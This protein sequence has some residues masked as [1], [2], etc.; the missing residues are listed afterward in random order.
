MNPRVA[1][2][3]PKPG[4]GGVERVMHQLAL[5]LEEIGVEADQLHLSDFPAMSPMLPFSG[6]VLLLTRHLKAEGYTA[7]I[8][9][10]E[11]ANLAA[12]LAR[13]AI[14]IRL[15]T[16]VTRHVPTH[17][18]GRDA[19][20]YVPHLYR[21]VYRHADG[22]IGVSRGIAEELTD[23]VGPKRADRVAALPNAVIG[24]QFMSRANESITHDWLGQSD[25]RCVVSVGRLAPQKGLELWIDALKQ[26]DAGQRPRWIAIGDGPQRAELTRRVQQSGLSDDVEFLGA[27]EN[28]LPWLKAADAMVLPSRYE[29]LPTVLIEALTLGTPCIASDC[30]TGPAEIAK[31]GGRLELIDD[32]NPASF[33]TAIQAV[34]DDAKA[35]RSF[36]FSPYTYA[37]A[38]RGYVELLGY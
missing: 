10:K 23:L 19:R 35:K 24:P 38:A 4:L 27:V 20:W 3:I 6:S 1:I 32:R 34:F 13:K 8:S 11:R 16:L 29:G 22:Y 5:G 15:R 14:G 21:R 2:L 30:R 17:Q 37:N 7:L 25:R 26:M 12:T 28:P 18:I 9:A 36:D 31:Q 33:V